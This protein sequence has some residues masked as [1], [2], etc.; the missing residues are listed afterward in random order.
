MD[1]FRC[2]A[3]K[4]AAGACARARA[5]GKRIVAFIPTRKEGADARASTFRFCVSGP[6]PAR[7]RE[8]ERERTQ[9][10]FLGD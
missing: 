2:K 1:V 9:P 5:R 4:S 8:R 6:T 10:A 7:V 3:S